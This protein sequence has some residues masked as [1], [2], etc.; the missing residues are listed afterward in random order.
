MASNKK[1]SV[2]FRVRS[3]DSLNNGEKNSC[4]IYITLCISA[5]G[6]QA[7]RTHSSPS[8]LTAAQTHI[9][10]LPTQFPAGGGTELDFGHAAAMNLCSSLPGQHLRSAFARSRPAA[11]T[12]DGKAPLP[13]PRWEELLEAVDNTSVLLLGLLGAQHGAIPAAASARFRSKKRGM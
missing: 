2:F 12:W 10:P 7:A 5:L 11:T 9:Q 8:Q 1:S 13:A 3:Q 6:A 4:S